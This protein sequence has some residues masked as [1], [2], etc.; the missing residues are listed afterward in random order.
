MDQGEFIGVD[1]RNVTLTG[2]CAGA[3]TVLV[4]DADGCQSNNNTA[5]SFTIN[6][7]GGLNSV[8][9]TKTDAGCGNDGTI[10]IQV[11]G[12]FVVGQTLFRYHGVCSSPTS[13]YGDVEFD[14]VTSQFDTYQTGLAS[15]PWSITA[16]TINNTTEKEYICPFE[17]ELTIG[18]ESSYS[19]STT[20]VD[21]TCDKTMEV[22]I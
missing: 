7:L 15:G 5:T 13:D 9:I 18:D 22:Q 4:R 1:G 6:D 21:T 16:G 2:L 11:D 17:S 19:I 14:V 10:S 20:I 12:Q 8:E 3:H